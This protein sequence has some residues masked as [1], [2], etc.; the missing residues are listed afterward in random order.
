MDGGALG[1]KKGRKKSRPQ[2]DGEESQGGLGRGSVSPNWS[3]SET[4]RIYIL[5][6]RKLLEGH[7][8]RN[9]IM[10]CQ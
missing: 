9:S 4:S 2:N 8:E 1:S 3:R 6:E 5:Y 10:P 7:T